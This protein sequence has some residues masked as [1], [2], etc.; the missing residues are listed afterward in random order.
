MT[1]SRGEECFSSSLK[2]FYHDVWY[3]LLFHYGGGVMSNNETFHL[4]NTVGNY[5]RPLRE[6]GYYKS[7][8]LV[9]IAL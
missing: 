7:P 9:G 6:P 3:V 2:M 4:E 1:T 5:G 8:F